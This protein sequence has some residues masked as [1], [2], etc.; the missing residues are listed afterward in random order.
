MLQIG[1]LTIYQENGICRVNDICE[2]TYGGK[3]RTY[4][5]LQPI[6][7]SQQ[8]TINIPVD[9]NKKGLSKLIDKAEAEEILQSF[10]SDGIEWIEKVQ[11]RDKAYTKIVN[12]RDRMEIAKVAKTLLL[13]K[14][15]LES[16]GKKFYRFDG[17]LLTNIEN[18]LFKEMAIALDTSLDDVT[19]KINSIVVQ[20][21]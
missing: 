17:E 1:D 8:L 21:K 5:V 14:H 12:S 10:Y 18:I 7:N 19:T 16:V 6:E 20:N 15:E 4:Y 9:N 13:K 2:K 11:E 3:T